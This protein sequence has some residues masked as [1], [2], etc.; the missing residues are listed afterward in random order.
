M[1]LSFTDPRDGQV[2]KTV[3]IGNQIWMAEN[4]NYEIEG[5]WCYDNNPEYA[6]KYGRLYTW[7]AAMKAAPE[8]WHLPS[9]AEFE[10][11]LAAVGGKNFENR[12]FDED[13]DSPYLNDCVALSGTYSHR[14]PED[15]D[16]PHLNDCVASVGKLLKSASTWCNSGNGMDTFGFSAL[17]AGYRSNNGSFY[18]AGYNANF[19]S[20]EEYSDYF[21]CSMNLYYHQ[22]SAHLHDA[23]GKDYAYSVRCLRD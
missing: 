19:W 20:A 22:D 21:S 14:S 15:V 16:G 13:V 5:S 17:L 10:T 23:D 12:I 9:M 7:E 4:L 18:D 3:Q 11:L 1:A 2:Y 6:Q 8:G